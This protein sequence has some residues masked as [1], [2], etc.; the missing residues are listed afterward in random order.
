MEFAIH[1]LLLAAHVQVRIYALAVLP[2][3]GF[4]LT[5]AALTL[6]LSDI[7]KIQLPMSVQDVLRTASTAK[8]QLTIA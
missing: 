1:A 4:S 6:A 8:A 5:T 3:W 2:I 7:I